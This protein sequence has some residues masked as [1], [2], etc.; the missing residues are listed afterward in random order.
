[1][2]TSKKEYLEKLIYDINEENGFL[3]RTK[4]WS[5]PDVGFSYNKSR[6]CKLMDDIMKYIINGRDERSDVICYLS[7]WGTVAEGII[8][9][10][11]AIYVKTPKNKYKEFMIRY[12]DIDYT[13][14]DNS[15]DD[16]TLEIHTKSGLQRDITH[17][18][19]SKKNIKRF[20][21]EVI[22]YYK[23]ENEDIELIW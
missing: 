17:V 16:I 10:T 19:F 18:M 9:T 20:L 7:D 15:S 23:K 6:T 5:S 12:E 4:L 22:A 21:D 14:Y 3:I 11:T 2:S 1:M 8:F 13:Y